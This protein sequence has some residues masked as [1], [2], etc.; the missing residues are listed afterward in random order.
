MITSA[1]GEAQTTDFTLP[2]GLPRGS[3]TLYVSACGVSSAGY[4][5]TY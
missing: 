4:A 3:Y 5:F 2:A 1:A